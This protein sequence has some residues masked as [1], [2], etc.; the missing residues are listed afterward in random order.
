MCRLFTSSFVNAI[1][2]MVFPQIQ[3]RDNSLTSATYDYLC[4]KYAGP[5]RRSFVAFNFFLYKSTVTETGL[6]WGKE[7]YCLDIISCLCGR[8]S[9]PFAGA[10][11]WC[12]ILLI[13]FREWARFILE[14]LRC[15]F[16]L[17]YLLRMKAGLWF[18]DSVCLSYLPT[19]EP[20]DKVS[21]NFSFKYAIGGHI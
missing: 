20:V 6:C 18:H 5:V 10:I 4:V 12:R 19:F 21:R 9:C 15:Q 8:K 17:F 3:G 7:R 14:L 2:Y 1:C 16:S 13:F 11:Y